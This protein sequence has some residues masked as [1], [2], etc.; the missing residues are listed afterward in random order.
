MKQNHKRNKN[1]VGSILLDVAF[2]LAAGAA[3]TF[4]MDKVIGYLYELE[5]EKTRR[6]E[7]NLRGNEYP[8]E[9]LA[10]KISEAVVELDKK[11]K[12]K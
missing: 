1:D 6:Y 12:Q 11:Q 9:A 4:V 5:D 8:P 2:G 10:E 3:A 7:V